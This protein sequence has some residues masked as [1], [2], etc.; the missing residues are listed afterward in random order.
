MELASP[1]ARRRLRARQPGPG[2]VPTAERAER[3]GPLRAGI[4]CKPAS[5]GRGCARKRPESAELSR[6]PSSPAKLPWDILGSPPP[7]P[8]LERG[9]E[10]F[11]HVTDLQAPLDSAWGG[12]RGSRGPLFQP[13]GLRKILLGQWQ[14]GRRARIGAGALLITVETQ[15][16]GNA[17]GC[18]APDGGSQRGGKRRL[19]GPELP[20]SFYRRQKSTAGRRAEGGAEGGDRLG[21]L[22]SLEGRQGYSGAKARRLGEGARWGEE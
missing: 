21:A 6:R 19:R 12:R 10:E 1:A 7:T 16:E 14:A 22:G 20:R 2:P 4:R 15:A 11:G 9:R 8:Q 13:A 5:A 3:L 18:E 17:G